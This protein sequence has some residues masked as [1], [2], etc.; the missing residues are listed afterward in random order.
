M[1]IATRT[2]RVG[3]AVCPSVVDCDHSH[4]N[5]DLLHTDPPAESEHP[6]KLFFY[7]VYFH[8][9]YTVYTYVKHETNDI[10][11]CP[12]W[13]FKQTVNSNTEIKQILNV[14]LLIVSNVTYLAHISLSVTSMKII[15]I[16]FLLSPFGRRVIPF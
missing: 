8:I 15:C 9:S 11:S 14:T 4:S 13:L 16:R 1:L 7:T 2:H 12:T 10:C 3:F 5:A 6:F